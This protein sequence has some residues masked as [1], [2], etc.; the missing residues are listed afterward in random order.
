M[1][2]G[3]RAVS[4]FCHHVRDVAGGCFS[5]VGDWARPVCCPS[6]SGGLG[7]HRHRGVVSP[8]RRAG[9]PGG[10]AKS[11]GGAVRSRKTRI[12]AAVVSGISQR[13]VG[14]VLR[15]PAV[16]PCLKDSF[17]ALLEPVVRT[18]IRRRRGSRCRRGPEW[19]CSLVLLNSTARVNPVAAVFEPADG[20]EVQYRASLVPGLWEYQNT[21]AAIFPGHLR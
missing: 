20:G 17:S 19:R 15:H 21:P 14:G 3:F 4:Q 12:T 11:P 9:G 2:R 1:R 13:R 18:Y 8:R 5:H 10:L 16:P 6:P 7:W